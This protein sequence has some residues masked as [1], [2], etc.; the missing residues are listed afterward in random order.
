VAP[1]KVENLYLASPLITE[2]FVHGE[3]TYHFVIVIATPN[4]ENLLRLA[5]VK[6]LKGDY[7]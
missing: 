5:E 6:G 3:S 7:E 2:V 1:D 4:K